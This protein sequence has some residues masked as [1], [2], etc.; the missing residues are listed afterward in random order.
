MSDTGVRFCIHDITAATM[1]T[2]VAT[3]AASLATP[4]SASTGSRLQLPRPTKAISTAYCSSLSS[5]AASRLA[6]SNCLAGGTRRCSG[7][8]SQSDSACTKWPT[9]LAIGMRRQRM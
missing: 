6:T 1:M 3:D 5:H 7:S 9:G 2:A 8:T 4:S